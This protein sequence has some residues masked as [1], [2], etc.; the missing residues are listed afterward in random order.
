VL[1]PRSLLVFTEP[2]YSDFLHSIE[3]QHTEDVPPHV[4]NA[5]VGAAIRRQ[6]WEGYSLRLGTHRWTRGGI[7]LYHLI[8]YPAALWLVCNCW[9][10]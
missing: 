10:P 9:P 5:Q 8:L 1:Q 7:F 4:L 2:L 3:A 6:Q